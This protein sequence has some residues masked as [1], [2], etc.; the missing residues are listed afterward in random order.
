LDYD[1][2]SLLRNEQDRH[3]A[4]RSR[5][6]VERVA[7]LSVRLTVAVHVRGSARIAGLAQSVTIGVEQVRA[8]IIGP[9][10]ALI[11]DPLIVSIAVHAV[12][13]ISDGVAFVIT[14]IRVLVSPA[15]V[16]AAPGLSAAA[17]GVDPVQAVVVAYPVPVVIPSAV[18]RRATLRQIAVGRIARRRRAKQS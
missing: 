7:V 12:A 15:V 16:V 2:E 4:R 1:V 9:V 10:V 6:R 13:G 5:L 8:P 11:R 18:L 14:L 17:E 3:L